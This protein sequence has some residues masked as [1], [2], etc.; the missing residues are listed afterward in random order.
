MAGFHRTI[1]LA[2]ANWLRGTAMP[3]A[4]SSLTL[5]L[6]TTSILDDGSGFTE[7]GAGYSRQAVTLTTP[8]HTEGVGTIVRNANAIVF[9]PAATNWGTIVSLA[10]LD[11]TGTVVLKGNLTAPRACPSGDTISIGIGVVEFNVV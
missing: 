7:P 9:G 3:A 10:V 4:P 11:Q 8:V 5:A 1:Q 6:S 2:L